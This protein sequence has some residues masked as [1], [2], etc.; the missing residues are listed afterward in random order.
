MLIAGRLTATCF[1]LCFSVALCLKLPKSLAYS[2]LYLLIDG[3][4]C[5]SNVGTAPW[6][7]LT[8]PTLQPY[9]VV[10]PLRLEFCTGTL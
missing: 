9:R 1:C 2:V 7:A 3:N 6:A 5:L 10:L 4:V 8:I